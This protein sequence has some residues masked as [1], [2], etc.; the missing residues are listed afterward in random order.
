VVIAQACLGDALLEIGKSLQRIH[1]VSD[2]RKNVCRTPWRCRAV[3]GM[4]S[5]Q[6]CNKYRPHSEIDAWLQ[7]N[8][9]DRQPRVIS[10]DHSSE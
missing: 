4:R 8:S 3:T 9:K 5:D 10:S 1:V 6:L 7:H 2:F